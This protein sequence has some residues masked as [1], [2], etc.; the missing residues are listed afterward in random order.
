MNINIL[1]CFL[2][3][4]LASSIDLF[5][6]KQ[7]HIWLLGGRPGIG[8]SIKYQ[9][10][11][12]EWGTKFDF[13]YDPVKMTIDTNRLVNL[14]GGDKDGRLI[15]YANGQ[16]IINH[17]NTFIED[18]VNYDYA[19]SNACNEWEINNYGN[20]TEVDLNGLLL[21]MRTI[22]LPIDD[23]IIYNV[24]NSVDYCQPYVT[25]RMMSSRLIKNIGEAKFKINLKDVN[26]QLDTFMEE[27]M[28][29]VRHGNGRDWWLVI[30]NHRYD[31]MYIY[32][33]DRSGIHYHTR[34]KTMKVGG[35]KGASGQVTFSPDGKYMA[36]FMDW[37]E[38]SN[39]GYGF[40]LVEFDRCGGISK[41]MIGDAL[42]GGKY[43]AGSGMEFSYDSQYL[44]A[45]NGSTIF[46]YHIGANDILASRAIVAN[47]DGFKYARNPTSI[48]Y[49]TYF[50]MLKLG[51]D[52][53]IYTFSSSVTNRFLGVIQHPDEARE[54]CDV[55]Q[56]DIM[57]SGWFDR[58]VPN[59]PNY[60]LGPLDG[61]ACDTLGLDNHPIAKFR[62]EADT[63]D[64]K[65]LRF[66]DLSYF[67]PETWSW[68]FGDGSPKIQQRSPYHTY[69]QNGT[70]KVCL[71]VSN[72]NSSNTSCRNITIGTSATDDD[73][74][75]V[76]DVTLF[77]NPVQDNLL[78]TIGD[79]IP[80]RGY[81]EIYNLSGQQIHKQRAYY[82]HNNVDMTQMTA[83]TYILRIVDG[84]VLVKEEKVVKM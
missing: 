16:A 44:Y 5:S 76:A 37:D 57:T 22:L 55:I 20:E 64:Y 70:Y 27:Y 7:D 77:P 61:S 52:G 32:L 18:T 65:R 21:F 41:K 24:Y 26:I 78:V 71:T 68:D 53:R 69:T 82:G 29:A 31:F 50:S 35:H 84:D 63:I 46:Q 3:I 11:T 42:P 72:E 8:S 58:T 23:S 19:R 25:Y 45:S 34:F 67:R 40:N 4:I 13:N 80:E 6:Q 12:M 75:S 28:F 62:Y 51:P 15:V 60:R 66:T 83:G 9:K 73:L 36:Y 79:Y 38:Q 2:F 49:S 74:S 81:I 56:H 47:Y 1:I 39:T 10:D 33:V 43:E 59:L 17:D 48:A 54:A 30:P 14:G